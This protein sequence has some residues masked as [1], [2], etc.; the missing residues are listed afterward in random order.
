MIFRKCHHIIK[1]NFDNVGE[2][3]K[4]LIQKFLDRTL[5]YNDRMRKEV[6]RLGFL[7]LD[8]ESVST[9]DE[10]TQKCLE[11]MECDLVPSQ[12]S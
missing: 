5:L 8:V 2:E 1:S 4:Y 9:A 12:R 11:L 7:C 6:D 10:L 3:E